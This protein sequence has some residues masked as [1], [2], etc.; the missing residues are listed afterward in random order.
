M[1]STRPAPQFAVL[2]P[3]DGATVRTWDS[4]EDAE[5]QAAYLSRA[6]DRPYTV[7]PVAD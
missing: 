4:R 3:I 2:S 1:L 6:M 5:R 7:R